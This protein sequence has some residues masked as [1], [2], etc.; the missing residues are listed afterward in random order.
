MG[1][2]L[3]LLRPTRQYHAQRRPKGILI[4]E[5]FPHRVRIHHRRTDSRRPEVAEGTKRPARRQASGPPLPIPGADQQ[6]DRRQHLLYRRLQVLQA[7]QFTWQGICVQAVY[8]RT[9][10]DTMEH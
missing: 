2:V 4:G 6:R 5:E 10:R 8:L 7:W 9:E 3:C 1:V